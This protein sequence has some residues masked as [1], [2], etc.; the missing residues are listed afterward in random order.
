MTTL[1]S[2]PVSPALQ[3]P[4]TPQKYLYDFI[5][6]TTVSALK[7]SLRACIDTYNDALSVLHDTTD[8]F[9][10]SLAALHAT[11]SNLP[12]PVTTNSA[13]SP[14]PHL[15]HDLELHAT[16][17]AAC[18]ASLVQHYDL[19]VTALKHTEGGGEAAS[20]ATNSTLDP[21]NPQ[22]L[23]TSTF[24]A[25]P[26]PLSPAD[27]LDMLAVVQKDAAEVDDV[28]TEIR[29]RGA[30]M[31]FL[32]SSITAHVSLLRAERAALASLLHDVTS[33]AR[34]TRTHYATI[35]TFLDA[36]STSRTAIAEGVDEWDSLHAFYTSFAAAYD[37]LILEVSARHSR[38]ERAKKKAAE[39]QRELDKLWEEDERM[40]EAFAREKGDW[41]PLDIWPSLRDKP[42]RW[43]V[44]AVGLEGDEGGGNSIPDVGRE[45][46]EGAVLRKRG[47]GRG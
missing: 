33:I 30:E 32:L 14:L 47:G 43:E 45:V 26:D 5:D 44:V 18:F 36:W 19:C 41:L 13:P 38:H 6:S 39:A 2:T 29:S 40:R 1:R 7:N 27:R 16:E 46:V 11:V 37:A 34:D 15:F 23:Q 22:P 31:E 8:A 12:S 17:A 24:A 42:R 35:H 28:V 4:S 20:A 3:P 9:D 21:S 25:P 10:D